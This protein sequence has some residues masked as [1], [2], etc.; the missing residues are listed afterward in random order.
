MSYELQKEDG[1]DDDLSSID[2]PI[3]EVFD[4]SYVLDLLSGLC[5]L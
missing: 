5:I 3:N 4:G 2:D 1:D